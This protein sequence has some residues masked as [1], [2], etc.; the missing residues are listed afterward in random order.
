LTVRLVV[1]Y[2]QHQPQIY[3]VRLIPAS[4]EVS[5]I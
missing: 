1:L 4:D 2:N 3:L 5:S